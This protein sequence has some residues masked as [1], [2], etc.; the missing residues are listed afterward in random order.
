MLN[1]KHFE[2]F[3]LKVDLASDIL[4]TSFWVSVTFKDMYYISKIIVNTNNFHQFTPEHFETTYAYSSKSFCT[5]TYI[6][7]IVTIIIRPGYRC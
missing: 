3:T 2:K 5:G 7:M 6:N 1:K 4:H